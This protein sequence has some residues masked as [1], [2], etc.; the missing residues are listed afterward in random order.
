M[1]VDELDG[2]SDSDISPVVKSI[3]GVGDRAV[4]IL[5]QKVVSAAA[6]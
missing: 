6:L 5:I 3:D 4:Q 1:I 2:C